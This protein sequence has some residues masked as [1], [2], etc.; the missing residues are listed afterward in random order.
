MNCPENITSILCDILHIAL[1]NIRNSDDGI[2]SS[3]QADHV[4]NIPTLLKNY[5]P[6]FLRFYLE[7][8]VPIYVRKCHESGRSCKSFEPHWTSL[9]QILLR[10][11]PS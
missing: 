2:L 8:E 7:I 9:E 6:T 4:H 3:M 1:I 5:T 10:D 11:E